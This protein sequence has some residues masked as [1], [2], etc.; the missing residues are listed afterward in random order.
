MNKLL[1][2]SA[3][4]P[5][6]GG[7][8][9]LPLA[10]TRRGEWSASCRHFAIA[11]HSLAAFSLLFYTFRS[12]W[13]IAGKGLAHIFLGAFYVAI[14]LAFARAPRG[15]RGRYAG[16]TAL[17]GLLFVGSMALVRSARPDSTLITMLTQPEVG[18]VIWLIPGVALLGMKTGI[19]E[20]LFRVALTHAKVGLLLSGLLFLDVFLFGQQAD[21][22]V[23]GRAYLLFYGVPMMVLVGLGGR[24]IRLALF[25]ALAVGAVNQLLLELRALLVATLLTLSLGI[26]YWGAY[27]TRALLW[28]LVLLACIGGALLG[29][30]G[31]RLLDSL[32]ETQLTDTR[33][34]LYMELADDFGLSDWVLGRGALGSYFS[35]YFDWVERND[36]E[37]GDS[38]QRQ[39]SEAG[40]LFYVLKVG[41][42]GLGLF[43]LILAYALRRAAALEIPRQAV[44]ATTFL[45]LHFIL[46][47]VYNMIYVGPYLVLFWVIV[48]RLLNG[49]NQLH[50]GDLSRGRRMAGG[51]P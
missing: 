13:G 2:V 9:S 10:E 19:A 23:F 39:M 27:T 14:M 26:A 12:T 33:T 24:W 4:Q 48:G 15:A 49:A 25:A 46:L 6:Y 29:T 43:F 28:R 36:R 17:L 5:G 22:S 20:T 7:L 41:L 42:V 8:T 47:F 34:F 37:T 11:L 50:G 40:V 38:S 16:R 44:G 1:P 35:P 3:T 30:Y 45:L 51:A 21:S 32:D 31:P 18:G